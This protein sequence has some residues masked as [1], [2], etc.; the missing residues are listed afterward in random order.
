VEVAEP[1]HYPAPL[2]H[3]LRA[4]VTLE[5]GRPRARLTGAQGSGILTSMARANA[6]LVLPAAQDIVEPGEQLDA[7]FLNDTVHVQ[8]PPFE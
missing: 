5:D 8:E 7:I 1:L 4:I 6:L 2:T 3:F